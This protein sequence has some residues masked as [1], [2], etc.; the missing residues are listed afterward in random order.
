[1]MIGKKRGTT[2]QDLMRDLDAFMKFADEVTGGMIFD[3]REEYEISD[4]LQRCSDCLW[5]D[6]C[7]DA[8]FE[9]GCSEYE[10]E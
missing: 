8:K 10:R 2:K 9:K 3:F 1:M 5:R 7:V 6:R 4:D